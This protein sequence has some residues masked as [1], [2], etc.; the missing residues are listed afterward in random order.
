M[1]YIRLKMFPY[2]INNLR[3]TFPHVKSDFSQWERLR[4]CNMKIYHDMKHLQCIVKFPGW[5]EVKRVL[6]MANTAGRDPR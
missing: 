5:C 1:S 2:E 4:R 6:M 3:C